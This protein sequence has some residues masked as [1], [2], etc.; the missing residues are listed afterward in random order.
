[1][2]SCCTIGLFGY[3]SYYNYK[4]INKKVKYVDFLSEY[5]IFITNETI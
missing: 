1:M 5:S 4:R 3:R 2:L